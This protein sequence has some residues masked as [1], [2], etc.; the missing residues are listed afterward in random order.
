MPSPRDMSLE[1]ALL[2]FT[3]LFVAA[4]SGGGRAQAS[5][6]SQEPVWVN[7]ADNL[8]RLVQEEDTDGDRKITVEDTRAQDGKRGDQRF[9]LVAKKHKRYEVVGTYY[10]SNLLQELK[11]AEDAGRTFAPIDFTKIFESPVGRISR[12]IRETYWDALTRRIDEEGLPELL[13]DEKMAADGFRYLYVPH[14]HTEAYD[15]FSG[16]ANATTR[17][18]ARPGASAGLGHARICE[19]PGGEAWAFSH[20]LS[21][22]TLTA[23]TPEYRSWFR[24]AASTR[25]TAGTVTS[26]PWVC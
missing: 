20:S 1:A 6:I 25:C 14:S 22:E 2:A 5:E 7:V 3:I 10:L 24:V 23:R 18:E 26:R 15:Y 12:S 8:G 16:L 19:T 17:L 13:I 11:L 9:W 21:N 4:L